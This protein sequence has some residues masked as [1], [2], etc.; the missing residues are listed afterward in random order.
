MTDPVGGSAAKIFTDPSVARQLDEE[1]CAVVDLLD[2]SERSAFRDVFERCAPPSGGGF[3]PSYAAWPSEAKRT[4]TDELLPLWKD[5]VE[6]LCHDHRMFMTSFLAKYPGPDSELP[7]HQDWSY[8]DE[9]RHRSFVIW[10]ALDDATPEL[11]NGPLEALVGSHAVGLQ[12]RGTLTPPWYWPHAE[13]LHPH[14]VTVPA[15][16]GQAVIMDNRLLHR[17]PPNRSDSM[18]LAVA[19]AVTSADADLEHS[20]GVGEDLVAVHRITEDFFVERGPEDLKQAP[21]DAAGAFTTAPLTTVAPDPAEVAERW[22]VD[23]SAPEPVTAPPPAPEAPPAP[24]ATPR[25]AARAVSVARRLAARLRAA[26]RVRS[27]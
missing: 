3:Q 4:V 17:S 6:R 1:G 15:A 16:A 12:K 19:V 5:V 8:V 2:E 26:A 22:G 20:T 27:R 14:L 18:R 10:V 23:L 24:A 21:L 7:L 9:T 13:A 25:A 11:D